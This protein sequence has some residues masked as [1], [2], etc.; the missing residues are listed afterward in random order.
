MAA[1]LDQP[2]WAFDCSDWATLGPPIR[3]V[4]Y[5]RY[6]RPG[7]WSPLASEIRAEGTYLRKYPTTTAVIEGHTDNVGGLEYN[8]KLSLKRAENVVNYLVEKFG[9]DRS[10]RWQHG[11]C[12]AQCCEVLERRREP[13]AAPQR[14]DVLVHQPLQAGDLRRRV[15]VRLCC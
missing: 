8:M 6:I 10:R 12:L 5:S 13:F 7:H 1:G 14:P 9:I 3:S 2:P 11:A 15:D 4:R